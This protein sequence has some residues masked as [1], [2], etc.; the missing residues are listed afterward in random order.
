MLSEECRTPPDGAL[1]SN[2]PFS[3]FGPVHVYDG[4][5]AIGAA[6]RA[7]RQFAGQDSGL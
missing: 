5:K 3:V 6:M 4:L 2:W 7:S 1:I